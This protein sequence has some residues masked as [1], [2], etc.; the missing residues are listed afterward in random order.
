MWFRSL[1][2]GPRRV[3]RL[4]RWAL[5]RRP[6]TFTY[7]ELQPNYKHYWLSDSDAVNSMDPYEAILWFVSR[8]DACLSHPTWARQF[9]VRTG[10][11]IFRISKSA[12]SGR[13][14]E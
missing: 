10:A 5:L 8:G 9:L 14:S 6:T 2:I 7:R 13:R 11:L 1:H 3:R 4:L 12:V